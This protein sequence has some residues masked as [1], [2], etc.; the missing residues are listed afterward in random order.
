M[1]ESVNVPE[2]LDGDYALRMHGDGMAPAIQAGDLLVVRK[3]DKAEAGQ[4]VI[5]KV[6]SEATVRR[7]HP[8]DPIRLEAD[9][10]TIEDIEAPAA[11]VKVLGVVVGLIRSIA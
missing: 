3:T 8:G 2:F 7:Y 10:T 6:N 11:D 4:I 1:T 9:N 5:A